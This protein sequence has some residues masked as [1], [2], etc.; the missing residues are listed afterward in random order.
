MGPEYLVKLLGGPNHA[1]ATLEERRAATSLGQQVGLGIEP[2]PSRTTMSEWLDG[3]LITIKKANPVPSERN[4]DR[5]KN[6]RKEY[7]EWYLAL[8]DRKK[9]V[10]FIDEHGM[11][12]WTRRSRARSRRG[13]PAHVTVPSQ[14]GRNITITGAIS[15]EFG[16]FLI[17][18]TQGAAT[19]ESFRSTAANLREIWEEKSNEGMIFVLDNCRA[20]SKP[21]LVELLAGTPHEVKLL[22]PWSPF[23]NP[24]EEV[25]SVHKSKIKA[26]FR[27]RR[28][29]IVAIDFEPQGQKVVH[30]LQAAMQACDDGWEQIGNVGNF[31][32][33]ME[34]YFPACIEKSTISS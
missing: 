24:I 28:R 10:V 21:D 16:L 15:F 11:N 17:E 2:A 23:L 4:S 22:P 19:K 20:H 12:L 27:E 9:N 32:H 33:H 31:F 14:K 6:M 18:M 13:Q 30:R 29:D 5:V 26:L 1:D 8:G 7:A 3:V 25:F 34:T